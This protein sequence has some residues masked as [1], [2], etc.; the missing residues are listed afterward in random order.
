MNMEERENF[1][2]K[3]LCINKKG[4]FLKPEL[5]DDMI[6]NYI[7]SHFMEKVFQVIYF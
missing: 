4:Q 2:Y 7:A 3:C 5:I 1:L 6:K